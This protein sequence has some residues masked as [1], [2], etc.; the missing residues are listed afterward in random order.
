[1]LFIKGYCCIYLKIEIMFETSL[2]WYVCYN[3]KCTTLVDR[4]FTYFIV[5]HGFSHCSML[6]LLIRES[7]QEYLLK[8]K[9]VG[10]SYNVLSV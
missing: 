6:A 7:L 3:N 10:M 1:M 8:S 9:K 5:M 4:L 2:L